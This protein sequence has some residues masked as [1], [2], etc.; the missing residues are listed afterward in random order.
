MKE[1]QKI[2][3][4]LSNL[5][6]GSIVLLETSAENILTVSI[7]SIKSL[8]E[9]GYNVIILSVSRPCF[10]LMNIYEKSRINTENVFILDCICKSQGIKSEEKKNVIHL[11]S[12][13]ALTEISLAINECITRIPGKKLVFIDSITTMLIYNDQ[14]IFSRF[15]H[16][17]L[18][19]LRIQKISGLMLSLETEADKEVMAQ[20]A[21][22]CDRIIKIK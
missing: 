22:L 20:I 16:Y 1:V 13:S 12:V 15:L 10:N 9:Q 3:K 8:I 2:K 7:H 5:P 17:L 19:K 4:E 14:N 11:K 21:Q 6:V 18:T